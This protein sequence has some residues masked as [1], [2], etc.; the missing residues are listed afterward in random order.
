M[1]PDLSSVIKPS[2]NG[3]A[4]RTQIRLSELVFLGP[5]ERCVTQTLLNDC[6]EP[7]QQEVET[8]TLIGSLY[9]QYTCI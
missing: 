5:S 6:V 1:N 8:S 3:I 2:V 9:I 4:G 7:G